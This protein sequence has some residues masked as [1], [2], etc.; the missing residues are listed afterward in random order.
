MKGNNAMRKLRL[1]TLNITTLA[2]AVVI[3]A[4]L[5]G[6]AQTKAADKHRFITIGSGGPKGVYHVVGKA[7]CSL[8]EKENRRRSEEGGI[9][10]RCRAPTTGGSV[11]NISQLAKRAM[12]FGVVSSVSHHHAYNGTLPDAVTPLP[13]LR[14]LFSIHSEPLRIVATQDSDVSS[15]RDLKGKRFKTG[16]PGSGFQVT[17]PLL[18]KAHGMSVDDF[19]EAVELTTTEQV[20]ALCTGRIDAYLTGIGIPNAG[21]QKVAEECGARIIGL[22]TEAD[23]KLVA[24]SPFYAFVTIPKGTY[25]TVTE[26]VRTFGGLATLVTRSDM[27][28]AIVY[29]LVRSVMENIED[30]RKMHP[31]FANLDP[32]KMM[33]D[34]LSAPLHPGAIKY[35]QEQGWM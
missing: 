14:S 13:Q 27:D 33:K 15:F 30:F 18:L 6:A 31:A 10:Y 23:E 25:A 28:E 32:Q 9:G 16:N 26:D 19:D 20:K 22:N 8:V 29:D 17:I 2:L 5:L 1:T 11:F 35:Y 24:E 34:G 7:I 21:D 3:A 4:F 12:T